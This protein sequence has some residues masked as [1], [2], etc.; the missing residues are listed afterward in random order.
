MPRWPSTEPL[1]LAAQRTLDHVNQHQQRAHG[2]EA[3]KIPW[4]IPSPWISTS[5]M[6]QPAS[7]PPRPE[8]EDCG[9]QDIAE[10]NN[11]TLKLA[12]KIAGNDID[13]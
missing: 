4:A 2:D 1:A 12:W 13:H 7:N 10:K 6:L 8:T 5:S 9:D 3:R 11:R